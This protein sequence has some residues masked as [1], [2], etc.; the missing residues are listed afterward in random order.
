[1]SNTEIRD[2]ATGQPCER[3]D[4]AYCADCRDLA[5]MRRA[6]DGTVAYKSDCA[7]ATFS[8]ITGADYDESLGYLRAVGFIPGN[9]TPAGHIARAFADAGYT[10][11]D[12]TREVSLDG[13]RTASGTGRAF[14]VS[15]QKGSKGHAW[16]I[17]G[18]RVN[19]GYVPPFRYRLY[20]VTA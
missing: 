14:Y 4:L 15:G 9:G 8:E 16:S 7:V 1:M 20:E 6:A 13:A 5:G 11:R 18:G 3:H 12:I 10:V 19:R 2:W 17:I